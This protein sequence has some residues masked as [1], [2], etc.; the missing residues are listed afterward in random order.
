MPAV[1]KASGKLSHAVWWTALSIA[2]FLLMDGALFHSGWYNKYVE[3]DSTTGQVEYR[4]FWLR[5]TIPPRPPEVLV[6]GDSRIAE[7]FSARVAEDTV[8]SKVHFTNL[9]M[10]GTSPRVWYYTLRDAD[11]ERNRF[12]AIAIA[13]DRYSDQ[14]EEDPSEWLP[15]LNYLAGRLRFSDCWGFSGSYPTSELRRRVFTGCIFRGA[16][17]RPDVLGL[18]SGYRA[19]ID[20]AADWRNNGARYNAAYTGKPEDLTGLS[21]DW[22]GRILHFT[23]DATEGQM[24]TTRRAVFPDPAPQTGALTAY[25]QRW[26]GGIVDLYRNSSTR[27]IFFPLP[28]APLPI[29]DSPVPARFLMS[30][31]GRPHISLLDRKTF[32]DL[33]RPDEFADGL[34]LNHNGRPLFSARLAQRLAAIVDGH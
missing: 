26:L 25:R 7:G 18:L 5:H 14:D 8:E 3:P 28:R 23:P 4:L 29:L 16:V 34:H 20:H 27:I 21:A 11:P 1:G 15:D 17:F 22:A 6:I 31:A 2:L 9:G 33:E 10:P 12:A 32:R 19:R 24:T 13:M 30:V